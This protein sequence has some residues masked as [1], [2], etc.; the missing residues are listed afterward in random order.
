LDRSIGR[1]YDP[2]TAAFTSVDPLE[3]LTGQPYAYAGADPANSTDPT[4]FDNVRLGEQGAKDWANYCARAIP[5]SAST[6]RFPKASSS[7]SA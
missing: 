3:G 4:G 7:V 1:Y 5:A 6:G 2:A